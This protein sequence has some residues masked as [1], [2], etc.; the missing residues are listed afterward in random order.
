MNEWI[1]VDVV[2]INETRG[3][4]AIKSLMRLIMKKRQTHQLPPP[5][6]PHP[7]RAPDF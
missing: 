5:T 7:W 1:S 3:M 2:C 6:P 4:K